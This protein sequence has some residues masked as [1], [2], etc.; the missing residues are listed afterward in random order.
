M[1]RD[2]IGLV[3][4]VNLDYKEIKEDAL[5]T[6]AAIIWMRNGYLSTTARHFIEAFGI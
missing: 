5:V 3:P 1:P 2:M 6:R 4:E